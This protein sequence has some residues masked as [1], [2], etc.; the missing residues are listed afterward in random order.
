MLLNGVATPALIPVVECA[1]GATV[2]RDAGLFTEGYQDFCYG[3]KKG[4]S[5]SGN[6]SYQRY[7]FSGKSDKCCSR[8]GSFQFSWHL[9]N[10]VRFLPCLQKVFQ[11]LMRVMKQFLI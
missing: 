6:K 8:T 2:V 5:V 7:S 9:L 3:T 11:I 10:I 1:F 4:Y